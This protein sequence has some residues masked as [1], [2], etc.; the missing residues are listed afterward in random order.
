MENVDYAASKDN[1]I[2]DCLREKFETKM[3][4]I[5]DFSKSLDELNKII[6]PHMVQYFNECDALAT[7][8]NP[9][10]EPFVPE[11]GLSD[12]EMKKQKCGC[13]KT[14]RSY[15]LME[16]TIDL[17]DSTDDLGTIDSQLNNLLDGY[18]EF[19]ERAN[20]YYL[21]DEEIA[22]MSCVCE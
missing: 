16:D 20:K 8:Y 4:D 21:T 1:L 2:H 10:Y 17:L 14:L 7:Y 5:L 11:E 9:Y 15:R 13:L 3:T 6:H 19:C 18:F 12:E 22:D